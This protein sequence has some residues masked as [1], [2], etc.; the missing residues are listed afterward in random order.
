MS[1]TTK[2]LC[3]QPS[4]KVKKEK[5]ETLIDVKNLSP[6]A[7]P[8]AEHKLQKKLHKCIKKGMHANLNVEFK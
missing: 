6:I 7:H 4:K 3:S 5:L 2:T 1:A 8:L